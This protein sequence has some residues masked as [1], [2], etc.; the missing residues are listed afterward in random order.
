MSD[1]FKLP[2]NVQTAAHKAGGAKL[3]MEAKIME[4]QGFAQIGNVQA[5]Q[6]ARTDAH[7]YL[8]AQMDAW[9]EAYKHMKDAQ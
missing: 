3:I 6:D 4:L 5:M 1:D 9:E 7:A 8:D 2:K